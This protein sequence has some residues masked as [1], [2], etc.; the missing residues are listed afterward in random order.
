VAGS[1]IVLIR[2]KRWLI[3]LLFT[4]VTIYLYNKAS[5][6]GEK[7]CRFPIEEDAESELHAEKYCPRKDELK[8]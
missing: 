8:Q 1:L 4:A 3:L 6:V 5:R 7:V 2:A